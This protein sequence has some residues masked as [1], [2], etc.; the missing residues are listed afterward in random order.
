MNQNGGNI[1]SG[2]FYDSINNNGNFENLANGGLTQVFKFDTITERTSAVEQSN[3]MHSKVVTNSATGRQ[4]IN[5]QMN[6][7]VN[8]N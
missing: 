8:S 6:S 4:H 3:T 7:N 2:E 1:M 5:Y